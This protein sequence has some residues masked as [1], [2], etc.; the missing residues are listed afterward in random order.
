MITELVIKSVD[1]EGKTRHLTYKVDEL[2]VIGIEC[3]PIMA[4]IYI[5]KKDGK[6]LTQ[7]HPIGE[8]HSLIAESTED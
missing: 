2:D 3:D 4:K 7:I 5:K 8:I 6:R 1:D